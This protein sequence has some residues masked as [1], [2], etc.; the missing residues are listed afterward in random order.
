MTKEELEANRLANPLICVISCVL[1]DRD[2][3]KLT[4]VKDPDDGSC[5]YFMGNQDGTFSKRVCAK[6][7][8]WA[9][10]VLDK[11]GAENVKVEYTVN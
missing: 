7:R 3:T 2:L 9:L 1:P 5:A 8:D 6:D 11:L 4:L 10:L